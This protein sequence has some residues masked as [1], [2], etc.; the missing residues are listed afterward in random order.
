MKKT[1]KEVEK[2]E[3]K[4]QKQKTSLIKM[5]KDGHNADVHPDMVDDYKK[6]GYIKV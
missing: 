5:E 1:S 3:I 6:G 4:E 2:K